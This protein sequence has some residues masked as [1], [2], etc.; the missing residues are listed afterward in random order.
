MEDAG[1][2]RE[3]RPVHVE[4]CDGGTSELNTN[5]TASLVAVVIDTR[6]LKQP[7]A[8]DGDRM[9]WADWALAFRAYASAV[10]AR[11]VVLMEHAQSATDPLELPV[12]PN[13][14]VNAQLWMAMLVKDGATKDA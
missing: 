7:V 11:T 6:L 9:K 12:S 4:I 2:C 8:L 1:T 13:N 3:E 14:Q 10:S 5:S